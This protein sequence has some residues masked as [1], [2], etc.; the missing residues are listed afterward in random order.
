MYI[1][2]GCVK[3]SPTIEEWDRVITENLSAYQVE[4]CD[5]DETEFIVSIVSEQVISRE[6]DEQPY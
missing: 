4:N 6:D 3:S 5:A 2:P 1:D